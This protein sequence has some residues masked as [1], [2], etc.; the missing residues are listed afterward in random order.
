MPQGKPWIQSDD[1]KHFNPDY[2]LFGQVWIW[3]DD[4]KH[5]SPDGELFSQVWEQ[6]GDCKHFNPGN[7]LFSQVWVQSGDCKHFNPDNELSS[8]DCDS[9][10]ALQRRG[11]ITPV[12]WILPTWAASLRARSWVSWSSLESIDGSRSTAC[13]MHREKEEMRWTGSFTCYLQ[14]QQ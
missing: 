3:S 4:C 6:S 9:A 7:E 11:S 1:C 13:R 2:E 8:H 10:Q 5:F 12:H 14:S